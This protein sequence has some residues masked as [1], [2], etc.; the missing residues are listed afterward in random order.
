MNPSILAG[1][2]TPVVGTNRSLGGFL[3][4]VLYRP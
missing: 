1:H 3:N 2:R 4:Q